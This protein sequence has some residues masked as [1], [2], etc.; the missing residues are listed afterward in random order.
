MAHSDTERSRVVRLFRRAG[1]TDWDRAVACPDEAVQPVF[2]RLL[3]E[4]V[5]IEASIGRYFLNED[6][7]KVRSA[8][9]R[10]FGWEVVVGT[11]I[12]IGGALLVRL[13]A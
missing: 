8:S 10:H 7:W 3:R 2:R 13:S 5:I 11:I 6:A 4:R 12:V 9:Y 1:A